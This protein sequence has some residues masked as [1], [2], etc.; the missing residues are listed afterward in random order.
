MIGKMAIL[1]FFIS[2]LKA[3][4]YS[5]ARPNSQ[6]LDNFKFLAYDRV[7][8]KDKHAPFTNDASEVNSTMCFVCR[9][10]DHIYYVLGKLNVEA[11]TESPLA[12]IYIYYQ[13]GLVFN[14]NKAEFIYGGILKDNDLLTQIYRACVMPRAPK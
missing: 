7:L 3:N 2:E 8:T 6:E 11:I 10:A 14:P 12:G 1:N 13:D 5:V 9:G 4:N